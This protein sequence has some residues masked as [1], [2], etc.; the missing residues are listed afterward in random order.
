M[1]KKIKIDHELSPLRERIQAICTFRKQHEELRT[2]IQAVLGTTTAT[3]EFN[4][5]TE[6]K[7]AF[8]NV[9]TIDVLDISVDGQEAWRVAMETY[10]A[11]IDRIESR[12]TVKLQDRLGGCRNANE[13]FRVFSN[14]N[15]LFYRPKV[16]GAIQQYQTLLIDR[17]KNDIKELQNKFKRGFANSQD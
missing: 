5:E 3:A 16:R 4:A 8:D 17:V 10:D 11:S 9:K 2:V 1:K 6:L 12:V 7:N 14:F 13:M 15:A